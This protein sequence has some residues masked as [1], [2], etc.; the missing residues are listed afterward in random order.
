[1]IET[2]PAM[3][4]TY[5]FE[6]GIDWI[7]SKMLNYQQR[8]RIAAIVAEYASE[9][10][11]SSCSEITGPPFK[12]F[13][14]IS[15]CIDNCING[16]LTKRNIA[17]SFLGITSDD[18][19]YDS[20]IIFVEEFVGKL[21][22]EVQKVSQRDARAL[23]SGIHMVNAAA[24]EG[25]IRLD[26]IEQSMGELMSDNH[27]LH[28]GI[29]R[30]LEEIAS[31]TSPIERSRLENSHVDLLIRNIEAGYGELCDCVSQAEHC[32]KNGVAYAVLHAYFD[33][34]IGRKPKDPK[35]NRGEFSDSTLLS[36]V[37]AAIASRDFLFANHIVTQALTDHEE[38]LQL[39]NYLEANIKRTASNSEPMHISDSRWSSIVVLGN[40]EL[41]LVRGHFQLY[42]EIIG[43][44]PSFINPL[45]R[46]HCQIL[47]LQYESFYN[48]RSI[49][50]ARVEAYIKD[51]PS[52]SID[53][54]LIKDY[55]QKL[56]NVVALSDLSTLEMAFED[57]PSMF[58]HSSERVKSLQCIKTG[59]NDD[60]LREIRDDAAHCEDYELAFLAVR[61]L[62]RSSEDNREE[63]RSFLRIRGLLSKDIALFSIFFRELFEDASI[64][65]YLQFESLYSDSFVYYLD[66]YEF[67]R[68]KDKG[69]SDCCMEKAISLI[70]QA[71][72][73]PLHSFEWISYLIENNRQ[74]ELISLLDPAISCFSIE[75]FRELIQYAR[76]KKFP[77][78]IVDKFIASYRASKDE[79][80]ISA[81]LLFDIAYYYDE[82][83]KHQDIPRGSIKA[84]KYAE[85]S[86]EKASSLEAGCL[87]ACES[88]LVSQS[89]DQE[90]LMYLQQ[91]DDSYA[92]LW[93]AR[94]KERDREYAVADSF[95]IRVL[96]RNDANMHAALELYWRIH[97]NE[98]TFK[99][100]K[101][102]TN[103]C[104][105]LRLE[106]RKEIKEQVA[107][108]ELIAQPFK[109]GKQ[110]FGMYNFS[111]KSSLYVAMR[112]RK[113]GDVVRYKRHNAQIVSIEHFPLI[114]CREFF[115][116]IEEFPHTKK[117]HFDSDDPDVF[118]Q[119]LTSIL[120][121][122]EGALNYKKGLTLDDG[123]VMYL[124]IESGN[125][126][127]NWRQTEFTVG[128][129]L[130][131]DCP[132]RRHPVGRLGQISS[133]DVYVLSLNAIVVLALAHL[134]SASLEKI[135]ARS[136]ITSSTSYRI[137]SDIE[138]WQ[139]TLNDG[140]GF[141]A[142]VDGK[143]NYYEYSEM[144][145]DNTRELCVLILDF[146]EHCAVINPV[147]AEVQ[148]EGESFF[149]LGEQV[150]IDTS[151]SLEYTFVTEDLV[152]SQFIDEYGEMKRCT[153]LQLLK[154]CDCSIDDQWKL[155]EKY[156][157]WGAD[158]PLDRK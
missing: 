39:L 120:K 123:S 94:I 149:Q 71:S 70:K 84:L 142:L 88:I 154:E 146:L 89:V 18:P 28:E 95:L 117:Y 126:L 22:Q 97:G 33:L 1:M 113:I 61:A 25:L 118:T 129:L 63:V 76:I 29:L 138:Q 133:N 83:N 26:S 50:K 152:E 5:A 99:H 51:A 57:S 8:K 3:G 11:C 37:G 41:L 12:D 141:L 14:R 112:G 122:N 140:A 132:F 104:V 119:Q 157:E 40:I 128:A 68:N 131:Q 19:E 110:L 81:E 52:W 137:K 125:V 92:D 103:C 135:Q 49:D 43:N 17:K 56:D 155:I 16:N 82:V 66:G 87:A 158:I 77:E 139:K 74:I 45:S 13:F 111:S 105:T 36:L 151:R 46:S 115:K 54:V 90:I 124:G 9:A 134:P 31:T 73:I 148:I 127:H 59:A 91:A 2:I 80:K 156:K 42:G 102:G 121:E 79:N 34:C 64:E 4:T 23:N 27:A 60:E 101:V 86:F 35:F 93:V 100:D 10:D 153:V 98:D 7:G 145:R 150:D 47:A 143:P 32:D 67:F 72:L 136:K 75:S 53:P 24:E 108:H 147:V 48:P 130:A 30:G 114:I 106:G 38:L 116:H 109:E 15:E 6:K 96:L 55:V 69:F 62:L 85:E 44:I 58:S 20:A 144:D 21:L 65:E 78:F 107:F